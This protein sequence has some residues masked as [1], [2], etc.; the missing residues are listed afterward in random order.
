MTRDELVAD[1]GVV[2]E[3]V[4]RYFETLP[5]DEL[6]L[7]QGDAIHSLHHMRVAERRLGRGEPDGA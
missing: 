5:L 2:R 4:V 3:R 1:F 7:R 6:L